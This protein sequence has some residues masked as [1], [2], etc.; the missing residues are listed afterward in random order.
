MYLTDEGASRIRDAIIRR[1]VLDYMGAFKRYI[2]SGKRPENMDEIE[3][4]FSGDWCDMLL[5]SH[6]S[7]TRIMKK[8]REIVIKKNKIHKKI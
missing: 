7:G 3:Q 5:E 1:A 2:K 4:F 8:I 6:G